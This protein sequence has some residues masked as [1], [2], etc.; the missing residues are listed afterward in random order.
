MGIKVYEIAK[1]SFVGYC[2]R[3]FKPTNYGSEKMLHLTQ[4]NSSKKSSAN[5]GAAAGVKRFIIALMHL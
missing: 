4:E 2:V 3:S 5:W 1:T